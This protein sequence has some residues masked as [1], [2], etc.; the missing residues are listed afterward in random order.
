MTELIDL[1]VISFSF[2][3][4]VPASVVITGMDRYK[5]EKVQTFQIRPQQIARAKVAEIASQ[6]Y[7]GKEIRPAVKVQAADSGKALEEDKDYSIVYVNN[8]TP[9]KSSVIVRGMGNY[10]G[11]QT[12]S[13]N[14]QIPKVTNVKASAYSSSSAQQ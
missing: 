13:F 8:K 10:T 4:T 1:R 11:A 6:T 12:V 9:G 14:I 3:S 5:G 7:T 2:C